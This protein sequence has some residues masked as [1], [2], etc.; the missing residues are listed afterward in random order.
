MGQVLYKNHL[1]VNTGRPSGTGGDP[2]GF[3]PVAAI[4]WKTPDSKRN[5]YLIKLRKLYPTVEDA[6]AAAL[7]EA[8]AWV[9]SHRL[10][11]ER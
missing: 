9:D 2:A 6:S 4:S 8:K 5:M 1:I 7:Q 10:D 11:F 3:I